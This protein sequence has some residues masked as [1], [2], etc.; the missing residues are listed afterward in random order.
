[1]NKDKIFAVFNF[2][3]KDSDFS[4]EGETITGT[5]KNYYTGKI[6]TFKNK[7]VMSI[8]DFRCALV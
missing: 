8:E 6:E 2:S 7:R 1:M 3:D 5:Y 4:L